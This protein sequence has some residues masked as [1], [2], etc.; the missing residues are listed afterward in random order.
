MEGPFWGSVGEISATMEIVLIFLECVRS[1]GAKDQPV[2][3]DKMTGITESTLP[4]NLSIRVEEI[5][6]P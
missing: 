2:I 3:S 1:E 4:D 5:I 6:R